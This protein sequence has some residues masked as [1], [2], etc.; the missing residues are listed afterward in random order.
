MRC[1]EPGGSDRGGGPA[2]EFGVGVQRAHDRAAPSGQVGHA[3]QRVD[4][5]VL[6]LVGRDRADAEQVAPR[7]GSGRR[8]RGVRARTSDDD[9]IGLRERAGDEFGAGPLAG[10]DHTPGGVQ[11]LALPF[12]RSRAVP[13]PGQ[14][15]RDHVR[16]H[17]DPETRRLRDQHPRCRDGEQSVD[18]H[19]RVA[20]ERGHR[21]RDILSAVGRDM[22]H[23]DVEAPCSEGLADAPVV[24]VAAA[25]AL[26]IV[27][28]VGH[29]EVQGR[30]RHPI[31]NVRS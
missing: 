16:Q 14:G 17:D 25:D 22:H 20:R 27:D 21:P 24:D 10:R 4:E 18:Q 2:R 30:V 13:D 3:R 29:Q 7:C 23:P 12:G 9:A 28:A 8:R 1:G 15:A 6:S 11:G 19:E 31:H 5:H 26:V